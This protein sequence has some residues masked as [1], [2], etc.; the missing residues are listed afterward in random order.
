MHI[1][2]A[3]EVGLKK[4][5]ALKAST[6]SAAVAEIV[7]SKGGQFT[8]RGEGL[9][10]KSPGPNQP[11]TLTRDVVVARMRDQGHT[12]GWIEMAKSASIEDL[13]LYVDDIPF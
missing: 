3:K 7:V 6:F 2:A 12:E 8:N 10:E 1:K 9:I 11:E 13:H 4:I 5:A